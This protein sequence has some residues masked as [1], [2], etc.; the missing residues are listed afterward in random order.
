VTQKK[1]FDR[2]EFYITN[3]CNLTCDNCNR[4]NN[5]RFKG[6]QTWADYKD[7]YAEWSKLVDF[8]RITLLGG[9]TL[10]NPT[11]NEWITGLHQLWPDALIE[12]LTNGYRLNDVAD[13]YAT[14]RTTQTKTNM[15]FIS[16]SIHNT[17]DEQQLFAEIDR[18][19]IKPVKKIP[20]EN[21]KNSYRLVDTNYITVYVMYE[22]EFTPA[23]IQ[24]KNNRF[25]LHNSDPI[26]AHQACPIAQT[27]SYHFIRGKMYKCGPVALFPEFD[28]QNTLDI[29]AEDRE[30]LNSYQPLT[31]QNYKEYADKFF[32]QLDNPI[33]QCKFCSSSYKTK[34][35]W[36][37]L[38][39]KKS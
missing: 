21:R 12:V 31:M 11:I 30:L 38:K 23:A 22:N 24:V 16:L 37:V 4:F 9:E 17:N 8:K 36:P 5:Y 6:F 3:V 10:L 28:Q 26:K 29:T 32:A 39:G 13:L 25:M 1:A 27:K 34:K 18:F 35:I 14:L 19:L 33:D 2:V 20:D 7:T 15:T